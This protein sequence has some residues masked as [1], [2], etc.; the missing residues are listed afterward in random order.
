MRR[1]EIAARQIPHSRDSRLPLSIGARSVF[2]AVP[3]CRA[4]P[5]RPLGETRPVFCKLAPGSSFFT[6]NELALAVAPAPLTPPA[7]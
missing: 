2:A 7:A 3:V 1:S 4:R 5:S 6:R